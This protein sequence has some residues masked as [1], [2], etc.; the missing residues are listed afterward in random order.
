MSRMKSFFNKV[1][2]LIESAS[3]V[4]A[5]EAIKGG[6]T[7]QVDKLRKD[8]LDFDEGEKHLEH[9]AMLEILLAKKKIGQDTSKI[10]DTVEF[11]KEAQD[12]LDDA[13]VITGQGV[14]TQCRMADGSVVKPYDT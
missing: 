3:R 5:S 10:E 11:S 8:I 1:D 4:V 12:I 2:S 6:M 7:E 13:L 14:Y 9:W